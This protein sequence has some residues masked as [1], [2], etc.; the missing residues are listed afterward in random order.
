MTVE[1]AREGYVKKYRGRAKN[2]KIFKV[3]C[4]VI[5]PQYDFH[6]GRSSNQKA[7]VFFSVFLF[8]IT[9]GMRKNGAFGSN[10]RVFYSQ[11]N[12]LPVY[13]RSRVTRARAVSEII[14]KKI[15]F[16]PFIAAG[17]STR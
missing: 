6:C 13:T 9:H 7:I 5:N 4:A 1:P 15:E 16:S 17:N 14:T 10:S 11:H 8:I 12:F 3:R 2:K